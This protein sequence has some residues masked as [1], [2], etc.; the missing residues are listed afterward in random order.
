VRGRNTTDAGVR[1]NLQHR[2]GIA[3]RSVYDGPAGTIPTST[4]QGSAGALPKRMARVTDPKNL[5]SQAAIP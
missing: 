4:Y 3:Q 1:Q 2:A 5:H